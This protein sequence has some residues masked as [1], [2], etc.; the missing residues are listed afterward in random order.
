MI[1]RTDSLPLFHASVN[2]SI[3]TKAKKEIL[4]APWKSCKLLET[5]SL[6]ADVAAAA[7]GERGS[8]AR[9]S[10]GGRLEQSHS[11]WLSA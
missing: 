7:A 8:A 4:D 1:P 11:K 3:N 10:V 5:R 2:G 9:L 6:Q